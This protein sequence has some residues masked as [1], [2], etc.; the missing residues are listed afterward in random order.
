MVNW[1]R[2]YFQKDGLS[3]QYNLHKHK[4]ALRERLHTHKV[5]TTYQ[6]VYLNYLKFSIRS[7]VSDPRFSP[8]YYMLGGNLGSLLYG[9]VSVMDNNERDIKT[10]KRTNNNKTTTLEWS[11]NL[12]SILKE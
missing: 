8:F 6:C 11:E 7:Y 5:F 4:K 2:S 12:Q 9:D 1:G 3:A 10:S